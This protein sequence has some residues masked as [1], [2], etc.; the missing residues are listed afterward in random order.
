MYGGTFCSVNYRGHFKFAC[1]GTVQQECDPQQIHSCVRT[2]R[3]IKSKCDLISYFHDERGKSI[4]VWRKLLY[5]PLD[6]NCCRGFVQYQETTD[7]NIAE[8][9]TSS[10]IIMHTLVSYLRT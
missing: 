3:L 6:F 9:S 7:V 5:V 2:L 10:S 8:L 4:F 1:D